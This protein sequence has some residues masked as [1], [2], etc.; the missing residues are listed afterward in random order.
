MNTSSS[1]SPEVGLGTFAAT[2]RL[3]SG[4][5]LFLGYPF[6][7]FQ[8]KSLLRLA[9]QFVVLFI[10][11]ASTTVSL[12]AQ[13]SSQTITKV[14][15]VKDLSQKDAYGSVTAV[16]ITHDKTGP[17]IEIILTRQVVPAIQQLDGPPRLVID[18]PKT[19]MAARLKRIEVQ[20]MQISAIR[21][22]QYQ[23]DPPITRVVVDL[24]APRKYTWDVKDNRLMVHLQPVEDTKGATKSPPQPLSVPSFTAGVQPAAVPVSP[25]SSGTM[26]LAG[27]RIAAGSSIT[28]GADTA[29]LNLSH[30]G[31][32]LVCPGTTVS[33]TSSQSGRDVMLGMSTGSLETHFTLD[34]SADS[35]LTPDFRILLPGPGEFHYAV[36]ADSYGNTCV[37]TLNGNT[38]SVIVAELMG[39]R[40]YQVKPGDQL[41]FHSGRLDK[42]E[43]GVPLDC[44]CPP[45]TPAMMRASNPTTPIISDA[46]L[47]ASMRL[48]QPEEQARPLPQAA[49]VS[50][51]RSTGPPPAQIV[52]SV[53]GPETSPLPASR[54]D[55]VHIQ[56]DAPLIFH[57]SDVAANRPQPAP[58]REAGH[59]QLVSARRETKL[60]TFVLPPSPSQPVP[61]QASANRHGFF[62]KMK[63][64]LAT[65]FR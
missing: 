32:I 4:G 36:S 7:D 38:A 6:R 1:P 11:A 54:P 48:A 14:T 13:S 60:Q 18:L 21:V 19:I 63:G 29:V 57:A 34:T 28:A 2:S 44:G 51:L 59:L 23:S 5:V 65:M 25:G 30:G 64:F 26:V 39:D 22:D 24:A 58:T 8:V 42:V 12:A 15:A 55:E 33:V 16:G 56:V 46:N 9:A 17:A 47:P 3:P 40:T 50:G 41:L 35:V 31:Q 27:N 10:L 20:A 49:D 45:P 62:G 37:R 61:S 43:A 52:L 53:I